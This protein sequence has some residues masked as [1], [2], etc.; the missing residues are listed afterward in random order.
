MTEKFSSINGFNNAGTSG[1]KAA[2]AIIANIEHTKPD[3]YLR[4]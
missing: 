2:T 1:S 3:L 4:A